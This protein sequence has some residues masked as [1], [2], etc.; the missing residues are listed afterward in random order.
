M[1][2]LAVQF[3]TLNNLSRLPVLRTSFSR[4]VSSMADIKGDAHHLS[5]PVVG[6]DDK[7]NNPWGTWQV[8]HWHHSRYCLE[9]T[10]HGCFPEY[11]TSDQARHMQD[12][13]LKDVLAWQWGRYRSDLPK[14]PWLL[15]NRQPT[16]NDHA[17]AFPLHQLDRNLIASP[18]GVKFSQPS[19]SLSPPDKVSIIVIQHPL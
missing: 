16:P 13:T 14:G 9:I 7:Y 8:L 17:L 6:S 15:E 11:E 19:A 10:S 18:P 5:K 12:K 4:H 3:G 2:H 1:S